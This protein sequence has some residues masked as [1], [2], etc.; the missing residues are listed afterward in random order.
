M[1]SLTTIL[2]DEQ[3]LITSLVELMKQEQQFLV[4]ADSDGLETITA[5]KSALVQQ[6]SAL[7]SQ[8][9]LALGAAGFA[10]GEAGM[11]PWLA[12]CRDDDAAA[13]WRDLL[14]R[15][16]AAKELNRVNGMLINK[17][18]THTQVVLNAMRTPAGGNDPG[19]YGPS[20]QAAA[21]GPSRR[22]VVG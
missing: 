13:L 10:A 4:K 21:G 7:S 3:R 16:R 11:E 14:E 9:H 6:M 12:A 22:F 8:R 1:T 15:T 5:Q 20:G 17:Q 2:R 18:M 19:V